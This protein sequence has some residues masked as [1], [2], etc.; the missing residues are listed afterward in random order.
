VPAF[1]AATR[2]AGSSAQSSVI[3]HA[4]LPAIARALQGSGLPPSEL[5]R[6]HLQVRRWDDLESELGRN[7]GNFRTILRHPSSGT[8]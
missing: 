6:N 5:P 7:L 4:S 3:M 8:R 1:A 2:T